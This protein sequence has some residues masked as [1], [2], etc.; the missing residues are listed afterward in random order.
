MTHDELV[1]LAVRQ[2]KRWRC[3]PICREIT[4]IMAT[5]E[6]PDAIGWKSDY[7]I[8]FECKV[9]R[10]DFLRDNKKPFRLCKLNGVGDFRF[11]I[12]NEGVIKSADELPDGWG[13]Y[14]VI[15]KKIKHK[16]GVRYDT[17][18]PNPFQGN[19]HKEI[20]IMRSWIRR[21]MEEKP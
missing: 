15:D 14:E 3:L 21:F 17:A 8:M 7:S 19:K 12:T 16:F 11:Y 9:S 20:I 2:L 5:G 6:I 4:T 1:D 10:A 18:V 13:C